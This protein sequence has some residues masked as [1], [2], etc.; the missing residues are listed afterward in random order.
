MVDYLSNVNLFCYVVTLKACLNFLLNLSNPKR[1]LS[2]LIL[3]SITGIHLLG[4]EQKGFKSEQAIGWWNRPLKGRNAS[5]GILV[6]L[7]SIPPFGTVIATCDAP[8]FC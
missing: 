2:V 3:F 5:A 6:A 4:S 1:S 7:E 8:G